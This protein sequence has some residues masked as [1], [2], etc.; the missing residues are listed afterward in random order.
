MNHIPVRIAKG[1]NPPPK[2]ATYV[3]NPDK[4]PNA[5][6]APVV[7]KQHAR[8]LGGY[9]GATTRQR[10]PPPVSY[11][12]NLARTWNMPWLIRQRMVAPAD[13]AEVFVSD[14][15]GI[16]GG[17]TEW[18]KREDY[19]RNLS[20]RGLGRNP[21]LLNPERTPHCYIR[22]SKPFQPRGLTYRFLENPSQMVVETN[23]PNIPKYRGW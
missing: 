17:V 9:T 11:L 5:N 15:R 8:L 3:R 4:V 19:F 6:G 23:P 14:P 21:E 10:N 18:Q 16:V 12:N 2:Y 1:E 20:V 7:A 13:K 22:G